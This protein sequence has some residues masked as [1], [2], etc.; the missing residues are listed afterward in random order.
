MKR[1]VRTVRGPV[2]PPWAQNRLSASWGYSLSWGS[3][4]NPQ[5]TRNF[6]S[7]VSVGIQ[8][9]TMARDTYN[10]RRCLGSASR[11]DA[12]NDD[13]E[14]DGDDGGNVSSLESVLFHELCEERAGQK[15][16]QEMLDLR[17]AVEK[18]FRIFE[19]EVKGLG[20]AF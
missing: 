20:V 10:Q 18:K 11:F 8:R 2:V 7:G 19:D 15:I 4:G 3:W 13:D 12:D 16:D 9:D 6:Q 14:Y 17:A 1:L 5:S